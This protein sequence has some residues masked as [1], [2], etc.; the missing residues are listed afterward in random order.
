MK[1]S[2]D[3]RPN[4]TQ[5]MNLK[6]VLFTLIL[7][8][9]IPAFS[10]AQDKGRIISKEELAAFVAI[11]PGYKNSVTVDDQGNYIDNNPTDY[12]TIVKAKA[13]SMKRG[14]VREPV[15]APEAKD[16]LNNIQKV[17]LPDVTIT[18]N[19]LSDISSYKE[20]IMLWIQNNRDNIKFLDPDIQGLINAEDYLSLYKVQVK[21]NHVT[22][23]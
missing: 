4:S 17:Q 12:Y 20:V 7:C 23:P 8:S 21:S 15:N 19:E 2:T 5:S 10:F 16:I 22:K 14:E 9:F 6:T 18:G 13:E 11:D 1:R 3:N